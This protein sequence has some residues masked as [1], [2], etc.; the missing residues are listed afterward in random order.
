[1]LQVSGLA[2]VQGTML[3]LAPLSSAYTVQ[4]REL[5]IQAA[6]VQ[7]R[8]DRV[9]VGAGF[10]YNATLDYSP[11]AVAALLTRTASAEA[12]VQAAGGSDRAVTGASWVSRLLDR[13]PELPQATQERAWS[14]AM[15]A[16]TAL[17]RLS[18][19][20]ARVQAGSRSLLVH[21]AAERA[22][23][24]VRRGTGDGLGFYAEAH[25]SL[26]GEGEGRLRHQGR[27]LTLVAGVGE[28]LTLL[29]GGGEADGHE[30]FGRYEAKRAS[31]ATSAVWRDLRLFAGL[32]RIRAETERRVDGDTVRS[33]RTDWLLTAR[34]ELAWDPLYLAG[35]IVAHRLGGF[36]ERHPL[37]IRGESDTSV[38]PF[39]E[40]GLATRFGDPMDRLGAVDADLALRRNFRREVEVEGRI[41][42]V[43]VSA[44]GTPLPRERVRASL[45]W[46]KAL[47]RDLVVHAGVHGASDGRKM[48]D[49]R[50]DLGLRWEW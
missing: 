34:A 31:I 49:R 28:N 18:S 46:S 1:P 26:A 10:F 4:S 41:G 35:G 45:T 22:S 6:Q 37:G 3:I 32:D 15:D 13:L 17:S 47:D 14:I 50:V 20:P 39:I 42:S 23:L 25:D 7:G 38:H 30:S 9:Q 8:F 16:D 2:A 29:V 19:L 24:A 40:A 44:D 5:L 48:L 12:A 36:A 21:E 27:G 43:T 33:R 11:T